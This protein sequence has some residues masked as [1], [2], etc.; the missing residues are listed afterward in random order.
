MAVVW[1]PFDAMV[2]MMEPSYSAEILET[3]D[4]TRRLA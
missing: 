3:S 4:A 2:V 1:S